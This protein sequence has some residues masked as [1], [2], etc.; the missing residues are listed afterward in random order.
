MSYSFRLASLLLIAATLSGCASANPQYYTFDATAVSGSAAPVPISAVVGPVSIPA[1][2]DRANIV[3]ETA[4]NR[5]EFEEYE[6]WAAPLDA[7][8]AQ[9]VAANVSR[10]LGSPQIAPAAQA[11]FTP[12][13]QIAISVQH[14]DSSKQAALLDALWTVRRA[15]AAQGRSG[16]IVV[17]EPVTG[18]DFSD[19]AAAQS[20]NLAKLSAN[21]AAALRSENNDATPPR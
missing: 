16:R 10:M 12:Q 15:G 7:L 1:T 4:P 11:N 13:Y 5:V 21:I 20:R 17:S 6:R 9:T 8:I 3:L 14:F 2:V 18:D 19:L